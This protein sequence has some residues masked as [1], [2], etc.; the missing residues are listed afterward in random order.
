[1][2]VEARTSTKEVS[3]KSAQT[4]LSELP[5]TCLTCSATIASGVLDLFGKV[6]RRVPIG[7]N[8]TLRI[9]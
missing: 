4:F 7:V 1:M 3:G 8:T 2:K 6:F 5:N 9:Q